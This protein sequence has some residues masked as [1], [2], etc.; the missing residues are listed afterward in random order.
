MYIAIW[1]KELG[2]Q[3]SLNIYPH[4]NRQMDSSEY[5]SYTKFLA[6]VYHEVKILL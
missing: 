3:H 4:E 5:E 2:T 1:K 6:T